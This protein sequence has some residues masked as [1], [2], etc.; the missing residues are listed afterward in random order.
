MDRIIDHPSPVGAVHAV[1]YGAA[2]IAHGIILMLFDE[3]GLIGLV[4][5]LAEPWRLVFKER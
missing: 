3:E 4:A 1:A 5:A 2:A